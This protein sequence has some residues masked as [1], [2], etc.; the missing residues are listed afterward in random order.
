M[1]ASDPPDGRQR[2]DKW[3]WCAR[4]A[5]SREAAAGLVTAGHVRINGQKTVKPGHA[6]KPGDV[7]TLV[8]ARQV[9]VVQ[10]RGLAN[11]RGPAASARQLY[12]AAPVQK[13]G[14]SETGTC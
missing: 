10:V 7:L 1:P 6:V 9:L 4:F 5:R 2:L 13:S 12:D 8:L 3:L 14:A 11:R